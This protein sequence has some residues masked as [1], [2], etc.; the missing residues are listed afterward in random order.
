MKKEFKKK[1]SLNKQTVDRLNSENLSNL[2]GGQDEDSRATD[3]GLSRCCW[4]TQK[5]L[6][7]AVLSA[8]GGPCTIK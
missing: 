2:V 8:A 6:E 4:F 3:C 1:L 7:C 5:P